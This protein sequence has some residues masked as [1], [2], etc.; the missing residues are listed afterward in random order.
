M[1]GPFD[2]SQRWLRNTQSDNVGVADMAERGLADDE[3]RERARALDS[4]FDIEYRKK[5]GSK[6]DEQRYLLHNRTPWEIRVR[7]AEHGQFVVA[8]LGQRVLV[9]ARLAAFGPQLRRLR[10]QHQLRVRP[11]VERPLRFVPPTSMLTIAILAEIAVVVW[12]VVARGTLDDPWVHWVSIGALATAMIAV[13]RAMRDERARREQE[14]VVDREEGD[15]VF[16]VGGEFFQG[17]EFA[18]R[19]WQVVNLIGVLLIGA[20]LPAVAIYFGTELREN[21]S[22]DGGL[23]VQAGMEGEVI[24]RVIQIIYLAVLSLF[25]AL[26][27][28]QFDRVRVG[29]LRGQWVRSIFR[30]DG[31]MR[32]LAGVQ[33]E[34]GD[35]LAEASNYSTD[36]VRFL[37]GRRSPIIL[38]TILIALGWTLLVIRTDPT[39]FRAVRESAAAAERAAE[40]AEAAG[41]AADQAVAAGDDVVAQEE[42][43]QAADAAAAEA[44][45]AA[46]DVAVITTGSV[47]PATPPPPP[48]PGPGSAADRAAEAAGRAESSATAAELERREVA[49]LPF[50]QLLNPRPSAAA[51][52]FLG[53]YFFAMFLVLRGY[54]RGDLRPKIYNQISAR[55]ITVVI[56]AYLVNAFFLPDAAS[57]NRPL[58]ALAFVAGIIP[59]A[60]LRQ[61]GESIGGRFGVGALFGRAFAEDRPLTLVDGIDIYDRERLTSEGVSDIE[62]LAHHDLVST[63]VSTRLPIGRLVDWTDQALLILHV[64]PALSG[65]DEDTPGPNAKPCDCVVALRRVGIRTATDLLSVA[66][67]GGAQRDRMRDLLAGAGIDIEILVQLLDEDDHVAM[68]RQ[69][70]ESEFAD[71]RRQ[72]HYLDGNGVRQPWRRVPTNGSH[73]NGEVPAVLGVPV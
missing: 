36:S 69:W 44:R 42:A 3:D 72:H 41:D 57:D 6:A 73:A 34:Y 16:G 45:D 50:F 40:A 70:R 56:I 23:H 59:T 24:S 47:A 31:R 49:I 14:R 33:A 43:V 32:T 51:M 48:E 55:L 5:S 22:F 52:A 2:R 30:L 28:F 71:V 27:F 1:L 7:D 37:G 18:R 54:L 11:N 39:D 19:I 46:D 65:A 26:M 58:W 62:A 17:S 15:I 64:Q 38:A 20:V 13:G 60:V 53:T 63:M 21:V 66:G 35:R 25:P 4:S 12:A 67:T 61:V 8:P 10:Q 29:T 9:G 68:V